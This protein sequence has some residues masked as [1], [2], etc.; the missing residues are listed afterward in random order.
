MTLKHTYF[1]DLKNCSSKCMLFHLTYHLKYFFADGTRS[2]YMISYMVNYLNDS[3]T[4]FFAELS[5]NKN[6]LFEG[7][8]THAA[9]QVSDAEKVKRNFLPLI[10][11]M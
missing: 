8:G 3:I 11:H 6:V 10:L 2:K 4:C 1:L 7:T 9:Q 5:L